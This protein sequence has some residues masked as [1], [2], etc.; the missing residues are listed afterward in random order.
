MSMF[1]TEQIMKYVKFLIWGK[2]GSGKTTFLSTFPEPRYWIDAEH[3]GD[4]IRKAGDSVLYT[5]SWADLQ[6]GQK[7][8]SGNGVGSFLVDPITILRDSLIDMVEAG[9]KNGM[10]FRDWA[11]VK[12]PDKRFTTNWQNMAFHVG[13]AA[14]EK[15]EYEMHRNDQGK[16]EPIKIGVKPDCDKKLIYAP[17]IVLHLF[18]RDGKHYATIDKIRIRKDLAVKTGL[19]VGAE[20]ENP[21]FDHFKPIVEAYANGGEVA[22]YSDD[23]E[24]GAKDEKVFEEIDKEQEEADKKKTFGQITRGEKKCQSLKIFGWQ[25]GAQ[26]SSTRVTALGTDDLKKCEIEDLKAYVQGLK[27][28]VELYNQQKLEEA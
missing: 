5:T 1:S 7:E 28:Q 6:S 20:I 10:T 3:S 17:D 2:G 16:L 18:V 22:H 12:K 8:A 26:T 23:R 4:H 9:T 11:R 13:I 14:H 15:D 25:D 24:T 19:R 21:T 27:K